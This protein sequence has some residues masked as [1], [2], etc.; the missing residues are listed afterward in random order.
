MCPPLNNYTLMFPLDYVGTLCARDGVHT[1]PGSPNGQD[2]Y[3]KKLIVMKFKRKVRGLS[4]SRN[5]LPNG[6]K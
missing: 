2:A 5:N 4:P 3:D 6:K 1:G